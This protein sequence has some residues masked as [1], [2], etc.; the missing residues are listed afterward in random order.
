MPVLAVV[1]TVAAM[2]MVTTGSRGAAAAVVPPV[3]VGASLAAALWA[4]RRWR[5][6]R[7]D[8]EARLTA[9]AASEAVLAERLRIA[10]DLHDVVSHGLGLITVRAAA[11]RHAGKPAEVDAALADIEE[12][13][14]TA[15]A[16]LRRMLTVLRGPATGEPRTPADTLESLPEIVRAATVMGLR[17]HLTTGDLGTV[18]PGVQL[19]VCRA[20]REGLSN[21][22][23]HAGPTDV[24][25]GVHRDGAAVTVTVAD[26]GPGPAGWRAA[27]GA[28]HG[29]LGLR[30][31]ITALGGTLRAG[32]VDGGFRL[33]ARIP[34]EPPARTGDSP[35][36]RTG[37]ELAA[38][39]SGGAS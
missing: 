5:A 3:L 27:P 24:R 30:E 11:T 25:I 20:V 15:T 22:A 14:R 33:T 36:G 10:G 12:A 28:G 34:D 17:P 31:R 2:A 1:V 23:R 35:P 32:P 8:Y 7:A 9:W 21:A 39:L 6:D 29:L 18:S 38:R 4:I 37:D 16:E 13:S 26:G 19:A